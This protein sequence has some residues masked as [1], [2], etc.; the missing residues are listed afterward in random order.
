M[1]LLL[2]AIIWLSALAAVNCDFDKSRLRIIGQNDKHF[3][4]RGNL[5]I[6]NDTFQYQELAGALDELTGTKEYRILVISLLNFLTA[7]ETRNRYIEDKFFEG[8]VRINNRKVDYKTH[9]LIGS[10]FSPEKVPLWLR[11]VFIK[12]YDFLTI[13]NMNLLMKE[14]SKGMNSPFPTIV[15]IH[16]SAGIDRA[17]YASGAFK[18]KFKDEPFEQ[19]VKENLE[20]MKQ[21]RGHMHFNTYNG[22]QWYCLSLG[23][24]EKECLMH[25]DSS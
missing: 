19:V 18:M 22:L 2:L 15:Y 5:P 3:L 7:K 24:S 16:C 17:G 1:R 9:F 20:I 25:I 14:I 11:K 10:L 13:D 4:V 6:A 8:K 12:Y 21:F 23:R